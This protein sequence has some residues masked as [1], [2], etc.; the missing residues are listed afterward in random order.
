MAAAEKG[1]RV[2]YTLATRLVNDPVEAADEKMLTK[3]IARYGRVDLHCIDELGYMKLD[4]RGAELLFQAL[5]DREEKASVAVA[6]MSPSPA[7]RRPSPIRVPAPRSSTHPPSTAPSSKPA[8][9][10]TPSP[11]NHELT[12]AGSSPLTPKNQRQT[13]TT[14]G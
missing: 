4:R 12:R 9:T 8:Q 13:G 2:E 10:P 14:N 5:T 6:S 7:G 1:Y 3:A 11:K